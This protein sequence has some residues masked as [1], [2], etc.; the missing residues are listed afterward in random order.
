MALESLRPLVDL[1]GPAVAKDL[2]FTGRHL[3]AQE[4]LRVGLLNQ[5]VPVEE[6]ENTVTS[7]A[8][9][10]VANAPLTV[11]A[12]KLTINTIMQDAADRDLEKAAAAHDAC[13]DSED[14]AEGR[15]AFMEKRKPKFIG[16]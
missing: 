1:V 10:I 7:Y 16:R 2:L 5:V 6:L 12:A 9:G 14:Y 11:R 4:A 3:N 13:M 15:R 8:A